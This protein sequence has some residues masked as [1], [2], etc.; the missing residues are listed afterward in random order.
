LTTTATTTTAK[1]VLLFS[2]QIMQL[3]NHPSYAIVA[4]LLSRTNGLRCAYQG[5]PSSYGNTNRGTTQEF[6]DQNDEW[7]RH[8]MLF[9]LKS[10]EMPTICNHN[11]FSTPLQLA[12]KTAVRGTRLWDPV[13]EARAVAANP[14]LAR[15]HRLEEV[16]KKK[17]EEVSGLKLL[18]LSNAAIF[19]NDFVFEGQLGG[20]PDGITETHQLVEIKC[21]AKLSP[22]RAYASYNDQVQSY[23]HLLQMQVGYLFQYVSET[24]WHMTTIERE[25]DWLERSTVFVEHYLA[26]CEMAHQLYRG[27]H[28]QT[29]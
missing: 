27:N 18:P 12:I 23:L 17:F 11:A 28:F 10:S 19:T 15:G 13:K 1:K 5:I 4:E 29:L 25:D 2:F 14:H 20:T 21:P 7:M 16:A 24:E 3:Q 22:A 9:K 6:S 26:L 8:R